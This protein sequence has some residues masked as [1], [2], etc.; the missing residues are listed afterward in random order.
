MFGSRTRRAPRSSGARCEAA[1]RSKST[2][3]P[4]RYSGKTAVR[5]GRYPRESMLGWKGGMGK[6]LQGQPGSRSTAHRAQGAAA[7][8]A[9]LMRRTSPPPFQPAS[10]TAA[11]VLNQPQLHASIDLSFMPKTALCT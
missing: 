4:G 11:A 10:P 7:V 5:V 3:R 9:V 8:A 2:C 6:G 1:K